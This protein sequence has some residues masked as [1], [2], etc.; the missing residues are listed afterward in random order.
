M[1]GSPAAIIRLEERTCEALSSA[2]KEIERTGLACVL[3]TGDAAIRADR[4]PIATQ[5]ARLTPEGKLQLCT[6]LARKSRRIGFVGDGLNDAA[7]M[8]VSSV[9][10]E[11]PGGLWSLTL[12]MSSG[13]QSRLTA[14]PEALSICRE[15]GK[16]SE[17]QSP[18]HSFITRLELFLRRRPAPSVAATL[19]TASSCIVTFRALRLCDAEPVGAQL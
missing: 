7:A 10:M 1:S 6:D 13:R 16:S 11:S 14:L 17:R 12:P 18:S 5:Y 9:S 2:L 4:I 15:S 3:M 8:S 19:M